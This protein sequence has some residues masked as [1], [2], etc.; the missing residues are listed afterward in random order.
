[1]IESLQEIRYQVVSTSLSI[2]TK[3]IRVSAT[4]LTYR[5][6]RDKYEV[7]QNLIYFLISNQHDFIKFNCHSL[8]HIKHN[9]HCT[10]SSI[11]WI[12][13]EDKKIKNLITVYVVIVLIE[14]PQLKYL[15]PTL[16]STSACAFNILASHNVSMSST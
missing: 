12:K 3:V 15:L 6:K 8:C 10:Y 9:L 11:L 1:M 14:S 5:I 7:K 16:A 4:H 2:V 13:V